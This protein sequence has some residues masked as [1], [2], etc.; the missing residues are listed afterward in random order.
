M[1]R[2]PDCDQFLEESCRSHGL[3]CGECNQACPRCPNYDQEEDGEERQRR[4]PGRPRKELLEI[5][6]FEDISIEESLR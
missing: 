6:V 4:R 2:C 5:D 3:Y 1:E